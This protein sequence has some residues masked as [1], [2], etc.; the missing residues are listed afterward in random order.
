MICLVQFR[1]PFDNLVK[2]DEM[3]NEKKFGMIQKLSF[4]LRDIIDLENVGMTAYQW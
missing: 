1:G 3:R 2:S 4:R